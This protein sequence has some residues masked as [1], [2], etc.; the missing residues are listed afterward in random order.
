[1]GV[2]SFSSARLFCSA[3]L[4]ARNHEQP[5]AGVGEKGPTVVHGSRAEET[6]FWH[7]ERQSQ[8]MLLRGFPR[9]KLELQNSGLLLSSNNLTRDPGAN[10]ELRQRKIRSLL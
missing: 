2:S 9:E 3:V 6:L 7:G 5:R 10:S 8:G 1:M 4:F